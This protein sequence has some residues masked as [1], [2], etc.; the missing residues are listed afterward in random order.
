MHAP[1][2]SWVA[3]GNLVLKVW[4]VS[5]D[6]GAVETA[7]GEGLGECG[8]GDETVVDSPGFEEAGCVGC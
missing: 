7:D 8:F 1:K 4:F 2:G 6:F 5:E 3:R